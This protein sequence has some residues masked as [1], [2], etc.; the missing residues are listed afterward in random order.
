M[1][2][3][4]GL[5]LQPELLDL[6]QFLPI[7]KLVIK[8]SSAGRRS[9]AAAVSA[10]KTTVYKPGTERTHGRDNMSDNM[11][12]SPKLS[13][14]S[15]DFDLYMFKAFNSCPEGDIWSGRG[16]RL[17]LEGGSLEGTVANLYSE[18]KQTSRPA[19]TSTGP[20]TCTVVWKMDIAF[21]LCVSPCASRS[22]I[23]SANA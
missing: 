7:Q 17:I 16:I 3:S 23:S 10:P 4:I 11:S 19:M 13:G 15:H 2:A 20:Q 1:Q 14:L 9:A 5:L 8:V 21:E 22:R 18:D 6:V 12:V